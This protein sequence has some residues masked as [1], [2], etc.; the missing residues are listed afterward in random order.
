MSHQL[1]LGGDDRTS[2]TRSAGTVTSTT[3]C[4]VAGTI[5]VE[6]VLVEPPGHTAVEVVRLLEGNRVTTVARD[7]LD[8][9]LRALSKARDCSE[10][11]RARRAGR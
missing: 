2:V 11:R 5:R 10:R 3:D 6:L 7:S 4:G 1:T 8:D 9:L